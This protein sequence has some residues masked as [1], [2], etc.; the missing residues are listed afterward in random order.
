MNRLKEVISKLTEFIVKQLSIGITEKSNSVEIK[1]VQKTNFYSYMVFLFFLFILTRNLIE[2]DYRLALTAFID[3]LIIVSNYIAFRIFKKVKLY[4]ILFS[5]FI[6]IEVIAVLIDGGYNGSGLIAVGIYILTFM[7]LLGLKVGTIFTLTV[8]FAEIII[9]NYSDKVPWIYN[10]KAEFGLLNIRYIA[11]QV[12]IYIF[13]FY[14]LK[15]QR[16]LYKELNEE[17]DTRKQLFLNIVHDLK[18]PLTIIHNS[19]NRCENEHRDSSSI[20]S[21]KTNIIKMEKNILNILNIEKLERGYPVA[22]TESVTNLSRVTREACELYSGYSVSGKIRINSKVE[23]DLYASIDEISFIQILNNLVENAIKYS[24]SEGL[25]Y[26]SLFRMTDKI[27]LTVKDTGIGI[28]ENEQNKIFNSYYQS[29][30][31]YS[32][33]YGLGI[34]LALAKEICEAYNGSITVESESGKGSRFTVLLPSAEISEKISI[35]RNRSDLFIP[36]QNRK[37]TELQYNPDLKTILLVEDNPEITDLIHN[38]FQNFYNIITASNGVEGLERVESCNNIDLIISDIMMPEMDGKE[39]VTKMHNHEEN[40]KIPVIFLTAKAG[41]EEIVEY[42]SLGAVDYICKPFDVNEL[43]TK[44]DSI[45]SIYLKMQQSLASNLS[46]RINQYF[47]IKNTPEKSQGITYEEISNYGISPKE[48]LIIAD[49]S[50]G[51][52]HKEIAYSQGISVNT[53][54]S[55]IQR[56]YK[57][58]NVQNSTSLLKIFYY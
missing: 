37:I 29:H 25:I 51:L 58:C 33:Y 49:L 41:K 14:N 6:S 35:T 9:I 17:K 12:G 40:K 43:R 50:K 48:E 5:L 23:D 44:V 27:S 28:P 57:K 21:L 34:G 7:N 1:Y 22:H 15:S 16:E 45:L 39:F 38:G 26:I 18:T 19:V 55:H 8:F 30:K 56:I 24:H 42:L 52:S 36:P 32:S 10:Y 54:K 31:G 3:L 11:S 13:S 53:V 4:S 2:N 20:R 46:E 47:S